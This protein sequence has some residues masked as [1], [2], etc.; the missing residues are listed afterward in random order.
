MQSNTT[1]Q[2]FMTCKTNSNIKLYIALL[3]GIVLYC[4]GVKVKRGNQNVYDSPKIKEFRI[5]YRLE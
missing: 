1:I 5:V 2:L 4:T 3:Y